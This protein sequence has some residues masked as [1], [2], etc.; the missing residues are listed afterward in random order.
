M[1]NIMLSRTDAGVSCGGY[2]VECHLSKK[3]KGAYVHVDLAF[4]SS[5][6]AGATGYGVSL[7]T[8]YFRDNYSATEI[9]HHH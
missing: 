1:R 6:K 7:I 2:F 4:P 9:C 8:E 5:T 3:F